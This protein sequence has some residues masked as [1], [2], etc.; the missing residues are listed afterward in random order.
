MVHRSHWIVELLN[1]LAAILLL[2]SFAMLSR[3]R[4]QRLITL[5]AWQG[6]VLFSSTCLVAYSSGQKE[7]YYS[8]ALTLLLKVIVL[9][10]VLYRLVRKLGA[11]WDSELLVNIPTTMLVGLGLVIFAFGLAQPISM[12]ANTVTRN[13]L[14]IALAVILLSFL[15][16]ITR[17]KAVT[18]V[19]GFLAME[20]GLFFAATS[21]TYG[22]PMIIELGIALDLLV[23]VF[24]LGI[25]FFQIREQFDSLD[26]H[27]LET[28]KED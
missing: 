5:F 15:M 1:L 25:F 20:N 11:Q 19:I 2:I 22:M 6:V 18:Q 8:A 13:T 7:L 14:G 16:M 3:R 26:L 9:P 4:T 24:I 27:H 23:A 12:M 21:A 10:W 28:L 17:R